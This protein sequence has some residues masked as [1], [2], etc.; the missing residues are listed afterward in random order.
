MK[1]RSREI[2]QQKLARI[3]RYSVNNFLKKKSPHSQAKI[4][5]TFNTNISLEV[6]QRII[7]KMKIPC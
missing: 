6:K 5:K 3:R 7:Y 2:L 4:K 1:V